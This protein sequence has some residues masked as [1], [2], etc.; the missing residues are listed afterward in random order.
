MRREQD[1]RRLAFFV[2]PEHSCSY[3]P[4]QRATTLF[5][6]PNYPKT[7]PVYSALA[8]HG[9][10]RSGPHLYRPHCEQ[11]QACIPVRVDAPRFEPD[12]SQRRTLLKNQD[13]AVMARPAVFDEEHFQLYANYL[14]QR[15]PGGGMDNPTRE[16]FSEFLIS[17]WTQ[18]SFYEF[19]DAGRLLAVAVTDH[20]NDGLSAVYTFFDP[21]VP[22]RG[23]GA[24]SI[25]WQIGEARAQ[26]LQWVYLGYLIEQT[27]KMSYKD[28]Y[29]PQ[30]RLVQGQ[31][32]ETLPGNRV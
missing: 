17:P 23:L 27:P 9:F 20:L 12:R 16:Q 21:A 30:Q 2:T 22:N 15:H 31:W 32:V 25:L 8:G 28:R 7:M 13:L 5:A 18:T 26:G 6:D 1:P 10:R 14:N 19:R 29:Q 3:L 24:F 11:C 4:E